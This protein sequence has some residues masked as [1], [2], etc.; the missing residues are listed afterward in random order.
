MKAGPW[1]AKT[2]AYWVAPSLLCLLIHWLGFTAWFGPTISRWLDLGNH[3]HG[4]H[5]LLLA[6]FQPRAQGTIRPWSERVFFMAGYQLFGLNAL[7]FRIVIFA[8]QF[9]DLVLVAAIGTRLSGLRAAGFW[10]AILWILNSSLA[11][12]LGWVCVYNEV[13]CAFFLLLAFYFLLRWIETGARRFDIY[14]WIVFLL[15]FGALELNVVYP[16]PGRRLHIPVRAQVLR[17][18]LPLFAVSALYTR[19]AHLG[20]AD[21]EDRRLRD[22]L[23]GS[24]FRTL[25]TF[26]EWSLG[27]TY[28]SSPWASPLDD[29]CRSIDS[30]VRSGL[31]RLGL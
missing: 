24:I 9:A 7:P 6:L 19:A 3:V 20:R 30:L 10:A 13:L 27:S 29:D 21:T 31:V 18:T 8:T 17:R 22:A 28:L 26:W 25:R 1:P 11:E 4:F 5:D 16:C 14:Q 2:V 15:G 12:P 23:Y